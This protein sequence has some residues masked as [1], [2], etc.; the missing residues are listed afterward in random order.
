MTGWR[1]ALIVAL[2]LLAPMVLACALARPRALRL[3]LLAGAVVVAVLGTTF[4]TA[5]NYGPEHA[6]TWISMPTIVG[7]LL[8]SLTGGLLL[9]RTRT[10]A[11]V[12][13]GVLGALVW[14]IHQVPPDPY[15][16]QTLMAWESGRFIRFHGLARWFGLLWPYA[17][18][19]WLTGR[20]LSRPA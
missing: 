17:A 5:L 9:D 14:M 4:S 11:V 16:A 8:G 18:F 1:D 13:L 15:Y 7:L 12:G 2:G 6:F 10:T 20:A 3:V 19:A